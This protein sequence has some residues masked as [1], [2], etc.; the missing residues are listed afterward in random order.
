M[1]QL[2]VSRSEAPAPAV[3][4]PN[5]PGAAALLAAGI[6]AFALA[7]LAIAGDHVAGFGHLMIFYRP[8]GPLSGVTTSASVVWLVA[9]GLLEWR[10]RKRSVA[11]GKIAAVASILLVLGLL[12]TFPPLSDLF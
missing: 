7:I 11:I 12:L 3:E 1:S 9:W 8:T 2:Q 10:W 5:G 6:G 4:V